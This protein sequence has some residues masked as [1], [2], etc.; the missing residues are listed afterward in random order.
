M[1][2]L[3][4]IGVFLVGLLGGVHCVGMCGGLVGAFS[5]QLPGQGPRF[6]YHLAA[7]I[8]R[9]ASYAIAGALAGAVG[10]TSLFLQRLFPVEQALYAFASLMLILLGLYL[11]GFS[12]TVLVL[13]KLGGGVWRK[14]QPLL[15]R[16]LPIRSL[17]RAFAAGMVWGWLPCGLVYSVLITALAS[18]SPVQGALTMA[19]FGVGTLPNL[20]AMGLLASH[21]QPLLRRRALRIAA[22]LLVAALGVLGL[23]RLALA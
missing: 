7:N 13:E 21:L 4:L 5:L 15:G 12:Q 16:L 23:M 1:Q 8:G 2:E 19:A 20:L 6:S 17:P 14:L 18:G 22:G 9:V 10:G 3:S 11:A